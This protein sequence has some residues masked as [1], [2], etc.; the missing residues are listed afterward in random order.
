MKLATTTTSGPDTTSQTWP[1]FHQ[2]VGALSKGL[3]VFMDL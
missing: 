3:V 2:G 1:N